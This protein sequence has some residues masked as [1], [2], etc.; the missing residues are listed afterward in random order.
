MK[1]PK[2]ILSI[3]QGTISGYPTPRWSVIGLMIPQTKKQHPTKLSKSAIDYQS[4]FS[5]S[6][7]AFA[8]EWTI[9]KYRDFKLT[10]G[11]HSRIKSE[12]FRPPKG[13]DYEFTLDLWPNGCNKQNEDYISLYLRLESTL[14]VQPIE[15]LY[16]FSIINQYNQKCHT[17]GSVKSNKDISIVNKS[18]F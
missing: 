11:M 17:K 10:R 8:F 3:I 13:K 1:I 4:K 6:T 14:K 9:K 5:S 16:K 15:V 12:Q 7:I 18:Q 2:F